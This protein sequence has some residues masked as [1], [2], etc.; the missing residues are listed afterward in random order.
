MRR[1]NA[2]MEDEMRD[3]GDPSR[4]GKS[5]LTR[6]LLEF[7]AN[8]GREVETIDMGGGRKAYLATRPAAKDEAAK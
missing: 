8:S 3:F 5:L 1:T 2:E 7:W 4:G 6:W